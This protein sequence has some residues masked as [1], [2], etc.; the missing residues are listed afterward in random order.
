MPIFCAVFAAIGV[1]LAVIDPRELTV[2][3][4]TAAL[5]VGLAV[6]QEVLA[7]RQLPHIRSLQQQLTG[8]SA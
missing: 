3:A 1:W 2:G 6:W 8:A 5:F 4:V 7:A